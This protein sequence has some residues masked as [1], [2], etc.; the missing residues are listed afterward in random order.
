MWTT[1]G[2]ARSELR[3]LLQVHP[4][5]QV[6]REA[7]NA[8]EA[9]ARLAELSVDLLLLDIRLPGESGFDLLERLDNVPALIFTTAYDEFAVR[10]FEVNALEL[11]T[12]LAAAR[13]AI[14]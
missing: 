5:V 1:S 12:G 9:V 2:L 3:R 13:A 6:I 4:D 11:V 10:A 14:S 7:A 8:D